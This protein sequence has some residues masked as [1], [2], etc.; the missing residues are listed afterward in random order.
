[1]GELLKVKSKSSGIKPQFFFSDFW[2]KSVCNTT[3]LFNLI[4][5]TSIS[6]L[7]SNCDGVVLE[8]CMD[9]KFQWQQEGL[10]CEFLVYEVVT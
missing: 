8:I 6:S 4:W 2:N 3:Y 10:I 9:H 5:D 7:I 1:M